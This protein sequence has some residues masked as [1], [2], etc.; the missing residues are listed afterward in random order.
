MNDDPYMV[1]AEDNTFTCLVKGHGGFDAR[2]GI[3]WFVGSCYIET[4]KLLYLIA[5]AAG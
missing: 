2:E 1:W 4:S 3:R 5:S